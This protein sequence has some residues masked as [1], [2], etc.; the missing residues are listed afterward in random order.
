LVSWKKK[1]AKISD[2]QNIFKTD[3]TFIKIGNFM[4]ELKNEVENNL[5]TYE[6]TRLPNG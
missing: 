4:P 1:T 5:S 6:M 2:V 3:C